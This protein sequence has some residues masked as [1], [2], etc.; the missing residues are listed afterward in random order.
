MS[1]DDAHREPR[2]RYDQR[3]QT[4]IQ[5][6]DGVREAPRQ[7]ADRSEADG[8]EGDVDEGARPCAGDEHLQIGDARVPPQPTIEPQP[9]EKQE[10]E[11]DRR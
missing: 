7:Q 9:E 6:N 5:E 4:G 8:A 3:A 10:L 1:G 11:R 2:Q